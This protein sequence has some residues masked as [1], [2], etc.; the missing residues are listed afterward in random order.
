MN[1]DEILSLEG[2]YSSGVYGKREIALVR[3]QG[4]RVWDGDGREYIDCSS[5]YGVA[6]SGH[7]HRHVVQAIAKQAHLRFG[8]Q[9]SAIK[10]RTVVFVVH[11]GIN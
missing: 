5:G 8:K 11:N 2:A 4:A 9:L 1:Q 7:C 6:L 10:R 3:G